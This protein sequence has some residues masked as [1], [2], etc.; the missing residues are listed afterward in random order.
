M[1][2]QARE[3]ESKGQRVRTRPVAARRVACGSCLQDPG[4]AFRPPPG[5]HRAAPRGPRGIRR[6]PGAAASVTLHA[7]ARVRLGPSDSGVS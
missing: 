3:P 1:S 4:A 6:T 5:G 2:C 7:A